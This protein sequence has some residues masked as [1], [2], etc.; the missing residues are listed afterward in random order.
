MLITL[1]RV[2]SWALTGNFC[3]LWA[4]PEAAD[5]KPSHWLLCSQDSTLLP[6][7]ARVGDA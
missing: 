2:S 5:L 1:I 7:Q 6:C 4:E 3:P